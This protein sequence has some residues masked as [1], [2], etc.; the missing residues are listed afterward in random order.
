MHLVP[1]IADV[2]H[3]LFLK[4][5]GK[6]EL[7]NFD[8]NLQ[9]VSNKK[10][11]LPYSDSCDIRIL[12]FRNFYFVYFHKPGSSRHELWKIY[13]NGEGQSFTR[14]FQNLI[15]TTFLITTTT[16]QLASSNSGLSIIGNTYYEDQKVLDTRIVNTDINFKQAKLQSFTYV[17]DKAFCNLNQVS[18]MGTGLF[19]LLSVKENF[20]YSLHIL[21][22]DLSTGKM[23]RKTFT[24]LDNYSRAATFRLQPNDSTLFLHSF[25]GAQVMV[26]RVDVML[27]E[28]E[29]PTIINKK[30]STNIA[31]NFLLIGQKSQRWLPLVFSRNRI[32]FLNTTSY[33]EAQP[34]VNMSDDYRRL[35]NLFQYPPN[36][37]T[38][39]SGYPNTNFQPGL[40]NYRSYSQNYPSQQYN[41]PP[42][43]L[44]SIDNNYKI[45]HDSIMSFDKSKTIVSTTDYQILNAG[46][47]SWLIMKQ[48]LP[49]A[50]QG[51]LLAYSDNT[52]KIET[53]DITVFEKYEY[54]LP[55]AQPVGHGTLLLPYRHKSEIGLVS[56]TLSPGY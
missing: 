12:P 44:M 53:R 31:A 32:G 36:L 33:N 28:V 1:N 43:R 40:T 35:E 13:A 11:P 25:L 10:I 37:N 42:V 47:Y 50:K 24:G 14:H 16:F 51:M 20:S 56:I 3:L 7:Y 48:E 46:H 52:N 41:A 21:K 6:S 8:R 26:S 5:K 55:H 19:I 15:D 54:F 45:V 30:L 9:F 4:K 38:Y 2:H 18:V 39:R 23:Y 49:R 27:N 34:L 29:E 22:G 17:F